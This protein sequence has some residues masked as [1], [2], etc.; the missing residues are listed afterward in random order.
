MGKPGTGG[1][2]VYKN[3]SS[4]VARFERTFTDGEQR[5]LRQQRTAVV[6]GLLCLLSLLVWASL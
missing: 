1:G 3:A 6:V 5:A 4:A 2:S